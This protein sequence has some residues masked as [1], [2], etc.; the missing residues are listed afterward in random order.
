M[1]SSPIPIAGT[2]WRACGNDDPELAQ[3]ASDRVDPRGP[4]GQPG[5][6]QAMERGHRLLALRFDGHRP[7]LVV[8]RGFEQALGVGAVGL[9]ARDIGPDHVRR[10]QGDAMPVPLGLPAPVVRRPTRPHQDSCRR[11][12]AQI[13]TKPLPREP[14]PLAHLA[15]MFRHGDLKD[16]LRHV[17]RDRRRIHP[18][19]PSKALLDARR[20]WHAMPFKSRE[21]SIPSLDRSSGS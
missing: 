4:G 10:Q 9:I 6:A 16:C 13:P 2:T 8:P 7:S 21:E 1:S 18:A 12:F 17:H 14:M 19:P 3:E 20:L 11:L 15:R 5:R